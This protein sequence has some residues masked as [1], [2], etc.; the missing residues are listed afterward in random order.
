M[1]QLPRVELGMLYGK[2]SDCN[3]RTLQLCQTLVDNT[4]TNGASCVSPPKFVEHRRGLQSV[5]H[6]L[7]TSVMQAA[8]CTA[9]I[10]QW[11]RN[12]AALL[13]CLP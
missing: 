12:P 5:S 11:D 9:L 10:R 7:C 6:V 8:G 2:C 4:N 13:L 3:S 1:F